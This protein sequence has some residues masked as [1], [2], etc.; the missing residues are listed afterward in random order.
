MW[1]MKLP[2]GSTNRESQAPGNGQM[3]SVSERS[4]ANRKLISDIRGHLLSQWGMPW[5]SFA[6]AGAGIQM[7]LNWQP[8]A[9]GHRDSWLSVDVR[10]CVV[11][12]YRWAAHVI[13]TTSSSAH[14]PFQAGHS[15][16]A[17]QPLCHSKPF[18]MRLSASPISSIS[19]ICMDTAMVP[20]LLTH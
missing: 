11:A 12:G 9:Q 3:A 8:T 5:P 17:S 20:R 6:L 1:A 15:D 18:C 19:S 10:G 14:W 16:H 2:V 4:G 7:S 13:T